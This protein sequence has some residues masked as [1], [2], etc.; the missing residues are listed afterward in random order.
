MDLLPDLDPGLTVLETPDAR[1]P[2]LHRLA[3]SAHAARD[4][5]TFWIDARNAASTR[6]FYDL[7]DHDRRLRSVRV[8]R[9]FTAYQH[10][11]L[12]R[13]TLQQAGP[14]TG[15]VVA[16]NVGAL[17]ADPDVPEYDREPLL[18][19]SLE[20]LAGLAE[21]RSIPV[22]ASTAGALADRVR[23][24]A[25]RVITCEATS[26]GHRYVGPDV[27]TPAYRGPGYWQ[28]TIAY[29]LDLFGPVDAHAR[30]AVH[31]RVPR[32]EG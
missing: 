9:A 21:A 10:H 12:V 30:A 27:E 28:T 11:S 16:A 26:E 15:L 7:V 8:A 13:R 14:R 2:S 19:S 32:V 18:R 6:V 31:E 1:S 29:W 17:Y 5:R 25:D 3:L 23:S 24:A 4:G 20:A 22:L